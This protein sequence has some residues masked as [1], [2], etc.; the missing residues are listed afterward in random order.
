[1]L[2]G[3][4]V[5]LRAVEPADYPLLHRW[6]NDPEVMQFWGRAGN[7]ASLSEVRVDEERQAARGTSRK[8]MIE[9]PDVSEPIGQID[10][11]DLDLVARSAWTSI[12]IGDRRYWSGGYGTDAM[13]ALL[14][15]LFQ[16]MGLHRVALTT[17][18]SNT[19]ARRSYEKNGFVVEGVLR[20]WMYVE[21]EFAD[22]VL[23]AVLA[24]EFTG[25][26]ER[27]SESRRAE[28]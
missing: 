15:Y 1:M 10:Y 26:G 14:E 2:F 3:T 5:T 16:E 9:L 19:R 8:Y 22:G 6:L 4:K 23:M 11:Y 12:M 18:A 27:A 17:L 28:L 7:T 24:H 20:E 25:R 21:G 13:A